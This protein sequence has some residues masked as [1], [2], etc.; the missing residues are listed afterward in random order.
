[1]QPSKPKSHIHQTVSAAFTPS[2]QIKPTVVSVHTPD[3]VTPKNHTAAG[4]P[5]P[6]AVNTS[7]NKPTVQQTPATDDRI[8]R[9][10]EV[11]ERTGLSRSMLYLKLGTGKYRDETFPRQI[12]LSKR[13]VGWRM[14]Q[15]NLWLQ[16]REEKCA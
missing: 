14:S 15:I 12:L 3:N 9:L 11:L 6:R 5:D 1:M 16:T 7:I 13:A 10:P 4:Q 8:L 2:T